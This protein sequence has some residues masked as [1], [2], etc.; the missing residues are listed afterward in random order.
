MIR[1]YCSCTTVRK[2]KKLKLKSPNTILTVQMICC[3]KLRCNVLSIKAIHKKR[4]EEEEI[5]REITLQCNLELQI[6]GTVKL[7]LDSRHFRFHLFYLCKIV[8]IIVCSR[9][10]QAGV[11]INNLCKVIQWF[12]IIGSH[13]F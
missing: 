8:M 4:K 3:S 9:V 13:H 7:V 12:K 6:T 5:I 11:I 1:P 2:Y 10:R